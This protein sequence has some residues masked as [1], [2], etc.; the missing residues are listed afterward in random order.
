MASS[1][2][3]N[4]PGTR[5]CRWQ[6]HV[7]LA[8]RVPRSAN[9]ASSDH[10]KL[11]V[12]DARQPLLTESPADSC[13]PWGAVMRL[14]L[15]SI[16]YELMRAPFQGPSRDWTLWMEWDAWGCSIELGASL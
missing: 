11:E 16:H 2:Q 6:G 13:W 5:D 14:D 9:E 15:A 12:D 7:L 4:A 10:V 3:R 1:F 8:E